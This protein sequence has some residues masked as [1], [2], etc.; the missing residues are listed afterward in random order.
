MLKLKRP[1]LLITLLLSM[2]NLFAQ[3]DDVHQARRT[4]LLEKTEG[5]TILLANIG[6]QGYGSTPGENHNF[7]YLT[8][9]R[10]PDAVLVM[11][12]RTGR[13]T[14][15]EPATR[16]HYQ[17][18][19]QESVNKNMDDLT[20][21]L[22]GYIVTANPL[23]M[24]PTQFRLLEK[25][26]SG[27][28]RLSHIR[29]ITPL[30]NAMRPIKNDHEIA[31]IRKAVDI[32][33]NG[34]VELMKTA[35]PGM[36]EKDFELF[37]EYQFKKGGSN[38]LGFGIHAA[39]GPNSTAVH[40]GR[41]DR[42]TEP[43][44]MLVFD[45]GA[46]YEY[47]TADITRSFPVSGTFTKEQREIYEVVLNA[48]KKAIEVMQPGNRITQAYEIVPQEL[49]KGLLKLGLLTDTTQAWQKTFWMMHGWGHHI[50]LQVHDVSAPA[51]PKNPEI[52]TPGM[53]YTMEPGLYFPEGYLNS[54]N[55]KV[56]RI[57]EAEWKAFVDQVM[58]AYQK[59]LNIGVRIEDD[60]LITPTGHEILSCGVPKEI[61]DIEKLMK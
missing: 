17:A 37:L 44:D 54:S 27:L 52:L 33:A 28:S 39:S 56:A 30:I 38:G 50:G 26:G 8:G 10:T 24:D 60:V 12:G 18:P 49:N 6:G 48:Q 53:I 57:P 32:T 36:S 16:G 43:G 20:K 51:D 47:Y 23:W 61:R 3:L 22:P 40:Y 42:T 46:E 58:P 35:E 21:E 9:V 59:Y 25:A 5:G 13:S 11:D 4:R 15:Y 55:P 31:L 41:N 1:I 45:V 2:S 34:L 29:N 14:I 7:F 19:A